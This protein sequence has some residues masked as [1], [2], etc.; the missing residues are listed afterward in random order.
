MY[1][2]LATVG[3]ALIT[4]LITTVA[5]STSLSGEN[6]ILPTGTCTKAVLS[7]RNSTL[8]ALTSC[9]ALATSKVTVPVFGL[10]IRPLGP[11]TLPEPSDGLHHVGSSDQC[12]EVGPVL[13]VDLLDHLF[14]A[15]VIR[16]RL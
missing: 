15:D 9:T 7:V 2:P 4:L 13:F 1:L 3:L 16:A 10:G 11:K 5:F 14:A 12:V 8:P 6:E